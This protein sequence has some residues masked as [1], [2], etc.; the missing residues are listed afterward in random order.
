MQKLNIAVVG[1]G[2]AGLSAAWLL[3]RSHHVTLYEG[4]GRPGG[5]ANTVDVETPEGP[6][7]VDTGFIVFNDL[8]YPNL[9]ALFDRLGVDARETEMSF[10]L[11]FANGAYEYSGSGAAGFF[12][13]RRNILRPRHWRLLRDMSRFFRTAPER[14]AHY[15]GETTLGAFLAAEGYGESFVRDHIVPMGAAIWSTA[16][17]DMLAFPA[18]S[19]IGFYANHGLLQFAGR[20]AWRTLVGGSRTY[21]RRLIADAGCELQLANAATRIV[22]HAGYALVADRRGALRPFD[23]V[24]IATHADEALR[25]LDGPDAAEAAILGAFRYQKNAAVL[26]RDPRWMPRRKRLWSSWNYLKREA[27]FES[28][29]CVTY[30]MNRLQDLAT[31]TDLFVT[32]NPFD[33]I[34]PKAVDG[35]F[36][37]EHPVFDAAAIAAQ[38]DLWS[39][40]G[41]RRTWFCG[42]YAGDGFHEDGIR[43]GLSVAEHLGGTARPWSMAGLPARAGLARRRLREDGR[44]SRPGEAIYVGTVRHTRLRPVEHRLSYRV[45]SLMFDCDRLETINARFRL[46]SYNRP[47]LFSLNDADHGEGAP[48]GAYLSDIANRAGCGGEVSRFLML[49]YPRVLGYVFNPITVYYGLDG[50]DR[51]RLLVHEVNNTFGQRATYVLPVADGQDGTI[52][53]EHEKRLYVSPF[54]GASGH[55]SFRVTPPGERLTLGVALRDGEGPVLKA[56]FTGERRPLSDRELMK[57]LGRTGWL[58]AKVT[59]GIHLE[60]A[61]LWLKGLRPRARPAAAARSV[62]FAS[63][64]R[65]KGRPH[66]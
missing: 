17:T 55:Y 42:S 14:I 26:H 59:A 5:H 62:H 7:A 41:A 34:H 43:S 20:P 13:Q 9:T 4:E 64:T 58:T 47:N 35:V 23:H 66:A 32:L 22:R 60:A 2:I 30:W 24:V 53:Q 40:Q 51:L 31:R 39:I 50:D 36:A 28:G 38:K 3:S 16:M 49:C 65:T 15:P 44:M 21:V 10:S 11:S 54:N 63:S 57:A 6:V 12:G 27:G 18:R 1:S 52:A 29:L 33:E 19:F 45:F 56:L 8:N 46:L 61:R 25:L 37:Y 48:L